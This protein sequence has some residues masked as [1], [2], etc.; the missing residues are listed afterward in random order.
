MAATT[1][2]EVIVPYKKPCLS[3]AI[4]NWHM[5]T[6]TNQGLLRKLVKNSANRSNKNV[7]T[8]A[9]TIIMFTAHWQPKA[10]VLLINCTK[11]GKF[12]V[13]FTKVVLRETWISRHGLTRWQAWSDLNRA[14]KWDTEIIKKVIS[15]S[16]WLLF[17]CITKTENP[18]EKWP[19]KY[20][21]NVLGQVD[22]WHNTT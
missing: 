7:N 9:K 5:P 19:A 21:G 10:M 3:N 2:D 12:K 15:A 16:R 13:P 18:D 8:T 6:S 14:E 17:L 4:Q 11:V 22:P 1:I 20:R